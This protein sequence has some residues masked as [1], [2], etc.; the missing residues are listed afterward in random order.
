VH[1]AEVLGTQRNM[2]ILLQD[3]N[4]K[5][6]FTLLGI[7]TVTPDQAHDFRHSDYAFEFARKHELRNVQLVVKF[8][9]SGWEQ[10]VPMP[11]RV[12]RLSARLTA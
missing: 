12:G 6:Y 5:L 11:L 8:V 9:D 10:I 7:W 1:K 3:V 4:T 2:R